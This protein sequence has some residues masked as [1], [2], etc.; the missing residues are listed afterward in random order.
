MPRAIWMSVII[1]LFIP[2]LSFSQEEKITVYAIQLNA[3]LTQEEAD[4]FAAQAKA[5][6][7]DP[8]WQIISE[9]T[10]SA[11]RSGIKT[12]EK[13]KVLYGRYITR[14]EA[15][16]VKNEMKKKGFPN[17]FMVCIDYTPAEF[18]NLFPD[19][20]YPASSSKR[21]EAAG[22]PYIV[23][24]SDIS[25]LQ[26]AQEFC[27]T[28]GFT[29]KEIREDQGKG[30][31]VGPFLNGVTAYENLQSLKTRFPNARMLRLSRNEA[32]QNYVSPQA[33]EGSNFIVGM[34]L[35]RSITA[36]HK[37][38]QWAEY[39]KSLKAMEEGS[40]YPER[41]KNIRMTLKD[42][43]PQKGIVTKLEADH[44]AKRS[45]ADV[46]KGKDTIKEAKDLYVKLI[47]GEIAAPRDLR[48]HAAI[49]LFFI[50]TIFDQRTSTKSKNPDAGNPMA[51]FKAFQEARDTYEFLDDEYYRPEAAAYMVG[52]LLELATRFDIGSLEEVRETIRTV[53][54]DLPSS[55]SIRTIA[56]PI[57]PGRQALVY[58]YRYFV[59]TLDLMYAETYIFEGNH[60]KAYEYY[61]ALAE[62][63][64]DI[65]RNYLSALRWQGYLANGQGKREEAIRCLKTVVEYEY[66]PTT[67]NVF[68]GHN[69]RSNAAFFLGQIYLEKNS[70][71]ETKEL[72]EWT[73][74]KFPDC[75]EKENIEKCLE[76]LAQ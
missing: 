51:Y 57:M 62:N 26:E 71:K 69:P 76:K 41:L 6:G 32:R 42:Q 37:N 10:L 52:K 48:A 14:T 24:T 9:T 50:T 60:A 75:R 28:A 72:Y 23:L 7:F 55:D 27:G 11:R 47:R 53:K 21:P 43:D 31:V 15:R 54:A 74:N 29:V 58:Q 49:R 19:D 65:I 13:Y 3:F 40:D 33:R 44:I 68:D 25:R 45:F 2:L 36:T 67:S 18:H 17:S 70:V 16:P 73:L 63:Y 61:K 5:R 66:A 46:E 64:P 12:P 59:S 22:D 34:K 8:V 35:G 39:V 38:P 56:D 4:T 1:C 30:L 20:L